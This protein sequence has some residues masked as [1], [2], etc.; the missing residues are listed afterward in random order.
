MIGVKGRSS[1]KLGDLGIPPMSPDVFAAVATNE[2]TGP[3][4]LYPGP[5][6]PPAAL[7]PDDPPLNLLQKTA[8]AKWHFRGGRIDFPI[9]VSA[10]AQESSTRFLK[11]KWKYGSGGVVES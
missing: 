4:A 6:S 7:Q 10:S 2:V 3:L 8:Y 5:P 11:V 9:R 1:S